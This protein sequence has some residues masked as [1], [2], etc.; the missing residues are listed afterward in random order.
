MFV[1]QLSVCVPELLEHPDGVVTPVM[2]ESYTSS[3]VVDPGAAPLFVT[4]TVYCTE[5]PGR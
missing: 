1:V 5:P 4:V 2:R 3:K